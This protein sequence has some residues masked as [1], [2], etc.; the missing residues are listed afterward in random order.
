MHH[1]LAEML[2]AMIFA[3]IVAL[4]LE[5]RLCVP[6]TARLWRVRVFEVNLRHLGTSTPFHL[7]LHVQRLPNASRR[8][9]AHRA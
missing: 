2:V 3:G 6:R 4:W 7:I 9:T 8:G 1:H 5:L